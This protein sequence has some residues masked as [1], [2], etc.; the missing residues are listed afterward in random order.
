MSII[1]AGSYRTLRTLS[2]SISQLETHKKDLNSAKKH[3]PSPS[4][5][6]S[7]TTAIRATQHDLETFKK[8]A[9]LETSEMRV[10]LESVEKR[11]AAIDEA[12][13]VNIPRIHNLQLRFIS[14]DDSSITLE[15]VSKTEARNVSIVTSLA[16]DYIHACAPCLQI[17]TG[18]NAI[19]VHRCCK[20]DVQS[21]I[22]M[23]NNK[24]VSNLLIVH[25]AY[26]TPQ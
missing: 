5:C 4:L 14:E 17:R 13:Q 15:I 11:I 7:L 9:A 3:L 19:S 18:G 23:Q 21:F 6:H 22:A 26:S 10:R 2:A 24:L 1:D 25:T 20:G 16:P 12:V 8:E